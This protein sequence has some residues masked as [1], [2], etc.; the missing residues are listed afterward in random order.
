VTP[1]HGEPCAVL[2][3][4]VRV[5]PKFLRAAKCNRIKGHEELSDDDA[6]MHAERDPR[7]YHVLA[8]WTTPA[9]GKQPNRR[10]I[11]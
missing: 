6:H 3:P 8:W 10:R 5:S 4:D 9:S 2:G 1:Q 11:K 7:T